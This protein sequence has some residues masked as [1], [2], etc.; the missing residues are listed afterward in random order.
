MSDI[1]EIT[2]TKPLENLFVCHNR[3]L[4]KIIKLF[5]SG[6]KRIQILH[7][8]F[9]SPKNTALGTKLV[10]EFCLELICINRQLFVRAD[11]I[12]HERGDCRFM[13]IRETEFSIVFE[14]S[15]E[16]IVY[17]RIIPSSSLLPNVF[18][19]KRGE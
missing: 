10:P 14:F 2:N 15:L 13:S 11:V 9:P 7:H 5:L 1:G 3:F 17:H 12:F 6:R 19:L 4:I 16:P 8:K 18:F